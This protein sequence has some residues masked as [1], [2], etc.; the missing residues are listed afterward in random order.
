MRIKTNATEK[1]PWAAHISLLIDCAV[2]GLM[3][4]MTEEVTETHMIG[5][6][7]LVTFRM[8]GAALCFWESEYTPRD[9]CSTWN[10]F[11]TGVCI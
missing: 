3:P 2:C 10:K 11:H 9:S 4:P 8:T 6:V 5:G 1:T 7:E